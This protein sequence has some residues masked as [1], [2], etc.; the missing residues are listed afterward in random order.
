LPPAPP[1]DTIAQRDAL[2]TELEALHEQL[3][4]AVQ[5]DE[6]E[7]ID[8]IDAL[9]ANRQTVI[10]GLQALGELAPIPAAIG[11]TLAQR[12]AEL[13]EVLKHELAKAS[14]SMGQA[15][16]KSKAVMRYRRER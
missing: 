2:L 1:D 4:K 8:A 6:P 7:V 16:R 14:K 15:A 10:D 11:A 3:L 5:S 9:V 13:T 12:E